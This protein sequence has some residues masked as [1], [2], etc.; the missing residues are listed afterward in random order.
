MGDVEALEYDE[1]CLLADAVKEMNAADAKA[2][3][4]Q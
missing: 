3:S 2:A 4:K 1:F